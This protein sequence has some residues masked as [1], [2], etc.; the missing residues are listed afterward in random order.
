MFSMKSTIFRLNFVSLPMGGGANR[1]NNNL[2]I[3]NKY[4]YE[5]AHSQSLAE[6]E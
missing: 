1:W 2:P 3:K 4:F 6:E 5:E